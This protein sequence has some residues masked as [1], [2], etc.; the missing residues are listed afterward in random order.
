M[1]FKISKKIISTGLT[2]VSRAISASTPLPALSGI[3]L[4]CKQNEIILTGSNSDISI[5][6]KIIK[7]NSFVLDV[8]N[9]GS[10]VIE[11][12]YI[13]E[14]VRKIDSDIIHFQIIDGSLTK[15]SGDSAE[16]NINGVKASEYPNIDFSK[17]TMNFL[18][19]S[20]E[21]KKIINQTTF[22]TSEKETRPILTGVNFITNNGILECV[23]T[24]S[25][26]LAKKIYKINFSESFN[27]N[28]PSKSLNEV[29]RIIDKDYEI[30]VAVSDKKIQFYLGNTLV[31]TRLIDGKFPDTSKL[32]PED[33]SSKL[34]VDAQDILNAIDR[35]SFIKNEGVSV[36][37]LS[38]SAEEAVIS[39][40]SQ[41]VGFS[42]E[43]LI[44][45]EYLGDALTLSFRGKY[46]Y[47]AIRHIGSSKIIIEFSNEVKPFVVKAVD[48]ESII[49]LIVPVKTFS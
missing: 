28:V 5:Q 35:A 36:V 22:A 33:C 23:A 41:E 19:N 42:K 34:I 38:L 39:T 24:D 48:D 43:N 31:Q 14:I 18:I 12:K 13:S 3:K 44:F 32:I 16:F 47:D 17:P 30:E 10:I 4:E 11:A 27:I 25:F 1:D 29:E 37:K 21:L 6:T 46:V 20:Y 7:D 9:T 26:R 2:T 15:I 45:N 40:K 8:T 49:Q